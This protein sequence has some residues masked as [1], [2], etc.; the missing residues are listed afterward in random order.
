MPKIIGSSLEEHREQMHERLFAALAELLDER[1]YDALSLADV[2]ARAGVS[3]TAMYNY[4]K[5]K[6][7]LLLAHT[8]HETRRYVDRLVREL[9]ARS[10]PVDQL[11]VFVRMQLTELATQHTSLGGMSGVLSE[12]GRRRMYEHVAP[13]WEQLRGIVDRAMR[14]RYL[15]REDL[16]VLLP[17]LAAAISP[18]TAPGARGEQLEQVIRTTTDFVLRGLGARLDREGRPRRLPAAR[19]D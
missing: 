8:D 4:F 6:E 2:A 9:A 18:R 16:D 15:P 3:R 11:R 10:N 12:A 7:T 13:L 19:A 1:G 14:E 5:D 17:V